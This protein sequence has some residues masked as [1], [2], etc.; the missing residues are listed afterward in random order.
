MLSEQTADG[1]QVKDT[2]YWKHSFETKEL[3]FDVKSF[4]KMSRMIFNICLELTTHSEN[5]YP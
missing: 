4:L 2:H 5:R 1:L 3:N